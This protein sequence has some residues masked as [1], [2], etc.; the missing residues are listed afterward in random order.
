MEFG[1]RE[2]WP[3]GTNVEKSSTTSERSFLRDLSPGSSNKVS[4]QSKLDAL[5]T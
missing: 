3:D 5:Q 4:F 1:S 2:F